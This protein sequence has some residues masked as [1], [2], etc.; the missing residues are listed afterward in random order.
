MSRERSGLFFCLVSAAAFSSSTFFGRIALD[1]GVGVLTLLALR[2]GGA[3]FLFRGLVVLTHQHLPRRNAALRVVGLGAVLLS[4]Q[5][6]LFYSALER[7]DASLTVLLLYTFPAM[8]AVA[9]IATGRE[10]PSRRKAGAVLVATT[11]TGLVLLGDAH[12]RGD[13]VGIVLGL[14][15]AVAAWVVIS[16]RVLQG[17]PP[18][19]VSAL[20]STGAALALWGVGLAIGGIDLTIGPVGW[21]AIFGTVLI[22]TV[23]A[24]ST[25]MAGMVRVGPTVASV[26]MTAEVP[27]AVTWAILLLGERLHTVQAVGG[28][29]VVA[30]V[31]LLQVRTIRWPAWA[32]RSTSPIQGEGSGYAP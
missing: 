11:G 23:L 5:A 9:S 7:L 16:D 22:S 2:Y 3:T 13:G 1:D 29:L 10:P 6:A 32:A 18:L 14:A 25:A 15:A 12:L 31:V 17:M 27:L 19:V 21:G 26:V 28:V 20:V 4:G 24:I 30:A 8:V